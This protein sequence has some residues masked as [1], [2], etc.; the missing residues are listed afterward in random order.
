MR[1]IS[2]GSTVTL[3]AESVME[4]VRLG[5][6]YGVPMVCQKPLAPDL[7][8]AQELVAH[9]E[10]ADVTLVVHENFRFQPWH[11]EAARL[12]RQGLL[13]D[14]RSISFRLRPGDGQGSSAY[15][16]RQPYFQKMERFLVHETAIHFI[17]TFRFIMGR[18]FRRFRLASAHEHGH[19]R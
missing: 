9:A 6:A 13:G 14:L 19:L 2:V 10:S 8:T 15:K 18:S 11:Q 4:I 1:G 17:D 3:G 16:N 5:S 7:A 12:V